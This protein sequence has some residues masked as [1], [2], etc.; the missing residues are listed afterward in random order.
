M[1]VFDL[2]AGDRAVIKKINISGVAGQRLSSLGITAGK[3]ISVLAFSLFKS[4]VLINCG[5]V[6]LGIRKAL[7]ENIE[8]EQCI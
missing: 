4:G 6:R 2:K 3:R 5:A 7:A 1:S 8:V